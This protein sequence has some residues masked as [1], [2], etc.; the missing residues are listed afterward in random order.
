MSSPLRLVK[1]AAVCVAGV[2]LTVNGIRVPRQAD[3]AA[4]A[5]DPLSPDQTISNQVT[6]LYFPSNALPGEQLFPMP[7]CFGESIFEATID[8][9]Q[10]LF[11]AGRLNSRKLVQCYIARYFQ[12]DEYTK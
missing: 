9:I 11:S 3:A 6:S 4:F 12:V 7:K 5:S 1:A 8:D 2:A 10:K